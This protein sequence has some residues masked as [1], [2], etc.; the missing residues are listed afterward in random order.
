MA[1]CYLSVVIPAYNEEGRLP[2]TL[3]AIGEYLRR[4]P[5]DWEIVVADDGSA[6]G[7]AGVVRRAAAVNPQIRLLTLPHRGKGWAVQQGMLAAIGEYRFLCDADLSM[8][9]EHLERLL[10]PLAPD[11]AIVIGSRAAPGAQRTGEPRRRLVMSRVFNGI[12]RLLATPGIAD[13]QCGFKVFRAD[14]VGAL[15]PRQTLDGFAF[16]AELLFLARRLGYGVGEVG[17]AWQYRS[18]SKVRPLRD[19]FRILRDLLLV[20]W[21]WHRG[22]Y[23]TSSG[24]AGGGAG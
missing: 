22:R 13:T 3:A 17:V 8:P 9:I 4:R 19:G 12:T 5:Y 18:E 24:G 10:P 21:R 6:D 1:T 20:R 11:A 14:A 7:T 16:D 2:G 23:R 15:F